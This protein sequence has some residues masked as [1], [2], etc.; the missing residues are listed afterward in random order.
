MMTGTS[1]TIQFRKVMPAAFCFHIT[2]RFVLSVKE[3]ISIS[4]P[5]V[6][7]LVLFAR[8]YIARAGAV[9]PVRT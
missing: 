6:L 9:L 4:I 5:V 2:G 8:N 3:N 1:H 7:D